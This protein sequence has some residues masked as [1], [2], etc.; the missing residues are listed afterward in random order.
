MRDRQCPRTGSRGK[1]LKL[2][3]KKKVHRRTGKIY[4]AAKLHS[5]AVNQKGP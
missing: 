1:C 3:R 2:R 5:F 4:S